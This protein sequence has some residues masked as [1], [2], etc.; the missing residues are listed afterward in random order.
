[1]ASRSARLALCLLGAL[2]GCSG[3]EFAT[4]EDD[5]AAGGLSSTPQTGGASTFEAAGG[6]TG[7]DAGAGGAAASGGA[8]GAGGVPTPVVTPDGV[9]L[10]PNPTYCPPLP[11]QR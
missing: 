10:P 7:V 4:E 9:A 1:M 6:T 3:A 2:A 8:A 11:P 5:L